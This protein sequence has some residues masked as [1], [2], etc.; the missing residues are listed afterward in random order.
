[1]KLDSARLRRGNVSYARQSDRVE[2]R[3]ALSE[4]DGKLVEEQA[5]FISA[6][7]TSPR[8]EFQLQT[9]LQPPA[10]SV[11]APTLA[12]N[13]QAARPLVPVLSASHRARQRPL[14]QSGRNL[15]FTCSA[16]DMF[17]K[18]DAPT[19]WDTFSCRGRNVWGLTRNQ[20]RDDGS[21]TKGMPN[22][23]TLTAKPASAST[24]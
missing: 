9:S 20:T 13:S 15:P 1:M 4:A 19:G 14:V 22:A 7:P 21:S 6:R 11:P 8:T 10:A 16:G 23:T 17:H 24:T 18:T 2:L 5:T 3:M 12:E